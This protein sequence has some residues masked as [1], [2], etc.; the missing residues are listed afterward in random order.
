MHRTSL[1]APGWV[2]GQRNAAVA[3]EPPPEGGT[4]PAT[5]TLSLKRF[6]D[7]TPDNTRRVCLVERIRSK[8]SESQAAGIAE[9]HHR[10]SR[11]IR[12]LL[13]RQL[14]TQ[15][16]DDEVRNTLGQVVEAI[17]EG[18]LPDSSQLAEFVRTLVC[19][20]VET[21]RNRTPPGTGS[22]SRPRPELP[23][24]HRRRRE[25]LSS[26]LQELSARE[27]ESLTRFYLQGQ[28]V[29]RICADNKLTP[30]QFLRLRERVRTRLIELEDDSTGSAAFGGLRGLFLA[31]LHGFL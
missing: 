17:R 24:S 16:L 15:E 13:G 28:D 10:F 31:L 9:L 21:Y 19:Q 4:S 11:G 8:N 23:V 14:R 12:F 7:Q 1:F 26:V 27:Q 22:E 3:T 18:K 6:Q 2:H 20:R 30:A 25:L 29:E 5:Q